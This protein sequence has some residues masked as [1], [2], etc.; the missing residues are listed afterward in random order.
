MKNIVENRTSS[1]ILALLGDSAPEQN[2]ISLN[3]GENVFKKLSDRGEIQ[4][5]LMPVNEVSETAGTEPASPSVVKNV[6]KPSKTYS[7]L[8]SSSCDKIITVTN[9]QGL[10]VNAVVKVKKGKSDGDQ[11]LHVCVKE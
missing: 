8:K 5:I 11:V 1:S 6:G 3:L 10:L 2:S 9:S 7:F 4:P